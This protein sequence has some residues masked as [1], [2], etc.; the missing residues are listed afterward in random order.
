MEEAGLGPL[1][2]GSFAR[3]HNEA[4]PQLLDAQGQTTCYGRHKGAA[5]ETKTGVE[6]PKTPHPNAPLRFSPKSFTFHLPTSLRA[7]L[8]SPRFRRQP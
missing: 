5:S 1:A 8:C 2:R 3:R 7:K 6:H 4:W